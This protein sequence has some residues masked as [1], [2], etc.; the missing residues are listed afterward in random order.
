MKVMRVI[1]LGIAVVM[2]ACMY[3]GILYAQQATGS[4]RMSAQEYFELGKKLRAE[5]EYEKANSAFKM[6]QQLLDEGGSVQMLAGDTTAGQVD[7]MVDTKALPT[8][9]AA[10]EAMQQEQEQEVEPLPMDE[11][12]VLDREIAENEEALKDAPTD[13]DIFYNLGILYFQ[14]EDY[15]KAV[16]SFESATSLNSRDAEAYYNL[17]VLY[18]NYVID[19]VKAITYYEKY[20]SMCRDKKEKKEVQSWIAHLK[21][22]HF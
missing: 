12:S 20:V 18:E 8:Q 16:K 6:A 1:T 22:Q 9:Q 19:Q 7:I 11:E 4:S 2:V 14:K 5:G 17:G 3:T 13:A 21:K 15:E 10:V